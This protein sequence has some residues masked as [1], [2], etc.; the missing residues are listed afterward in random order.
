MPAP[1]NG[2]PPTVITVLI[3]SEAITP[4]SEQAPVGRLG[5]ASPVVF[6]FEE[7]PRP[8]EAVIPSVDYSPWG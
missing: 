6:V 3:P 4:L 8:L 7:E 1:V 5:G 2:T